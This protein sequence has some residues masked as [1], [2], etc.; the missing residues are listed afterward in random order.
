[1]GLYTFRDCPESYNELLSVSLLVGLSSKFSMRTPFSSTL[2]HS[3]IIINIVD[4]G[5]EMVGEAQLDEARFLYIP[6]GKLLSYDLMSQI[7]KL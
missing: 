4:F 5:L 2:C 3:M 1:M 6:Y 7:L